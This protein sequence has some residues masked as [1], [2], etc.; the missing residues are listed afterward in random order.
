MDE[1]AAGLLDAGRHDVV[2]VDDRRGAGDQ[3]DVAALL[4]EFTKRRG[5]LAGIVAAAALAGQG[6]A[7]RG[8]APGRRG[9][10]L[11]EHLVAC[12]GQPGLHQAGAHRPEWLHRDKRPVGRLGNV[13][14]T[15]HGLFRRRVG[16]DLHCC[17]HLAW[18]HAREGRQGRDSDR[19]VQ[20]VQGVDALLIDHGEAGL[21]GK[22]IAAAR[23]GGG[24]VDPL[25]RQGARQ[26]LR[27][28]VFMHVARIESRGDDRRGTGGLQPAD[29]LGRQ[30]PALGEVD[31][32]RAPAVR[33]DGAGG[34]VDRSL[35][36]AHC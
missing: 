35:S 12:P 21:T 33:Q 18:R 3:E 17:H 25:T 32:V 16:N 20:L 29:I 26:F 22:V 27:R 5:D 4:L 1:P 23:E 11:V 9:D 36:E 19:F 7:E 8:Q 28:F 34:V 13:D 31:S 10:R 30:S 24:D 2:T 6:A 14:R 15:M